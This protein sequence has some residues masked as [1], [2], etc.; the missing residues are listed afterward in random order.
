MKKI[1]F[2][3]SAGGH[4]CELLQLSALFNSYISFVV[5]EKEKSTCNLG[6]NNIMGLYYLLS[7]RKN[8]LLIFFLKN[9]CN[10][11]KSIFLFFYLYPDIIVTTG[12]NTAV[13]I[14]YIGKLFRKKI[15]YIET[16]AVSHSKTLSGK[17][18]YPI[19]D[20]FFV[21]WKSMLNLYPK[22]IYKGGLF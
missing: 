1:I 22:A 11:L 20:V 6:L 8:N 12:A 4:L 16:F 15:V 10:S 7:A 5:T 14:C 18:I 13:P 17:L 9:I 21:Q 19:A 2:I 3:S